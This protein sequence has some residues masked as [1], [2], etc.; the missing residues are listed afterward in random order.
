MAQLPNASA[1]DESSHLPD[2]LDPDELACLAQAGSRAAFA[3]LVRRYEASL[4]H[5]LAL[6]SADGADVEELVQESFLRA[7]LKIGLYRSDWKFSTWLFALGRRIAADARR[8]ATPLTSGDAE[9]EHVAVTADPSSALAAREE[10]THIWALA[11]RHLTREQCSA[12]WLRY[13][14]DFS[15]DEVARVL[16]KSAVGAR[17]LLFRARGKLAEHLAPTEDDM[18]DRAPCALPRGRLSGEST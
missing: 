13:A 11:E 8:R 12:L 17:V 10:G 3:A 15:V 18:H 7:W 16:G 1:P 5:F 2:G 4:Y 14:E 6:R 9:L